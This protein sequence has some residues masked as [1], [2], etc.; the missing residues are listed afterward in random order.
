MAMYAI[1]ATVGHLISLLP[2]VT[3]ILLAKINIARRD[4]YPHIV[5]PAKTFPV[6]NLVK[7]LAENVPVH[8]QRAGGV[9]W[10]AGA[11]LGDRQYR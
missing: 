5:I 3:D 6:F 10:V 9:V 7:S 1:S 2:Q 11:A 4:H 8:P